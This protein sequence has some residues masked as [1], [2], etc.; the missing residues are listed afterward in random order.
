MIRCS[1]DAFSIQQRLRTRALPSTH[2]V[3]EGYVEKEAGGGAKDP[4]GGV[5]NV[6]DQNAGDHAEET[7]DG[8]NHVVRQRLLR[9]HAGF[10]ENREIAWKR[11]QRKEKSRRRRIRSTK[12]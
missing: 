5:G 9:R 12:K 6:A 11:G 10:Q 8:R 4:I 7:K 1:G 2:H 3:D